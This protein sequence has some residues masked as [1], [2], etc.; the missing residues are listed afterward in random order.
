LS[1]T[2]TTRCNSI[3]RWA[4]AHAKSSTTSASLR[5]G[6]SSAARDEAGPAQDSA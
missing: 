2:R 5:Q 6:Q 3:P 1:P 4:T